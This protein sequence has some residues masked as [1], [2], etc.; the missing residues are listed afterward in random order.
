MTQPSPAPARFRRLIARGTCAV[1]LLA[2]SA[3]ALAQQTTNLRPPAPR[4]DPQAPVIMTVITL[5]VL[6]IA[7]LFA[8]TFPSK[9]GH[10][11]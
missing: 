3:G 4:D 11:D 6:V 9:R 8:A 2:C 10:Q 5:A 1:V 7:T